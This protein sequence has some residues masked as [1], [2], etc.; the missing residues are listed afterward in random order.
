[1][2][3]CSCRGVRGQLRGWFRGKSG[4]LSRAS[5]PKLTGTLSTPVVGGIIRG[6]CGV[7]VGVPPCGSRCISGTGGT[8][9]LAW[10]RS[11]FFHK[12]ELTD[13]EL[14][15]PSKSRCSSISNWVQQAGSG[16]W[17]VS[18][19]DC[20]AGVVMLFITHT[21]WCCR[22]SLSFSTFVGLH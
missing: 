19:R 21:P 2:A 14:K 8:I 10:G 18:A 20:S 1:M 3:W 7:G 17:S 16:S 15:L 5:F 13:L 6:T 4:G 22:I 9:G 11:P 12:R